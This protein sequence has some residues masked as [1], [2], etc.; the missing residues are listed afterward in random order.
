MQQLPKGYFAVQSE[1]NTAPK[2]S[3]TFQG[4]TY[5]VTAGINLFSSLDEA[6]KIIA[7]EI[8]KVVLGGLPYQS[9]SAP[10]ILF[11]S[12]V[13]ELEQFQFTQS[14]LLFG[15]GVGINPNT[16]S[17][18]PLLPPTQNSLRDKASESVLKGIKGNGRVFINNVNAKTVLFDG[19][20]LQAIS[21]RDF[22]KD[23]GSC[24]VALR[25][26]IYKGPYGSMLHYFAPAR[27]DGD[28][29]REVEFDHVRSVNFY[30][31]DFGGTFILANARKTT[32]NDLCYDTTGQIFGFT[33]IPRNYANTV[34]NQDVTEILISN[35]YF[36]NLSGNNGIATACNN[37]ENDS[38][39]MTVQNT[40]FVN[41]SRENESVL[42]PHLINQRCSLCVENCTFVDTRQNKSAAIS[43]LG[44][45]DRVTVKDCTIKGFDGTWKHL[46][47]L[48][49]IIPD[50]I[51]Q[52]SMA[53]ETQ[54]DDSHTVLPMLEAHFTAMENL[55]QGRR[56]YYGDLHVHTNS[57]GRSDGALPISDWP[58]G[59]DEKKVDFA[60][61][62]DHRQ[63]RGF[64]LPEWNTE[65]FI[66]GTEPGTHFLEG[67]NA[68]R[69][70]VDSIHYNMLFPHAYGLAMVLA[71]FPEYQFQGDELNGFF[72]YPRFTKKRFFEL[73][74]FVQSIGGIIVHPHPKSV[75]ASDD[76][77]DYYLGEHTFM[78]VIYTAP[79]TPATYKNYD[80]W[81]KLL[82]LGKRVYASTGSDS[83]GDVSNQALA[84]FYTHKKS[85]LTFFEQMRSADFTVG[86]VGMKMCIDDHP[87]GSEIPYRAGM[88]LTLSIDDFHEFAWSKKSAYELRIVTDRGVAYRSMFSG[89]HPQK[90]TIEVQKRA[91]YRAEIYDLTNRC[92]CAIGNPIW[93]D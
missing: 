57:G 1:F 32:I 44:D 45:G 29:N 61:I 41:A 48:P 83:H 16:P 77:L 64:F 69:E 67:L 21:V 50:H 43:I 35:S 15:N 9:F 89:K 23:G 24:L 65:R 73:T 18:D 39:A 36:R 6:N 3:F 30:D 37:A 62:V 33:T 60:A 11:S 70:G 80:L 79:T 93:L 75:L 76:P 8:P 27:P 59:M 63:M 92:W 53:W 72:I 10:V 4:I 66:Y 34:G 20:T 22:R 54:T 86:A 58:A 55:Y 85:G 14:L 7:G 51:E 88:L 91:F 28:L 81:V 49:E 82:A 90:L 19:L 31:F 2:D 46:P 26:L 5:A 84:T 17:D 71:N 78:E 13:H 56:A 68:N 12:G 42:N 87:M 25:N 38:L 52:H 74:E 47:A 40:V